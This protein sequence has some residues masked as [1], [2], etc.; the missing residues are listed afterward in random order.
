MLAAP[1][2][3]ELA[4]SAARRNLREAERTASDGHSSYTN[5]SSLTST[6]LSSQYMANTPI[7]FAFSQQLSD[8][9]PVLSAA[10]PLTS[11][12]ENSEPFEDLQHVPV[13]EMDELATE[14]QPEADE[15]LLEHQFSKGSLQMSGNSNPEHHN[16]YHPSRLRCLR[17][18]H[19][20]VNDLSLSAFK[21]SIFRQCQEMH[22]TCSYETDLRA[23]YRTGLLSSN[24]DGNSSDASDHASD[25]EARPHK[26]A[27]RDRSARTLME[28]E[29]IIILAAY[30]HFKLLICTRSPFPTAQEGDILAVD[31]WAA[32]CNEL[33]VPR[34]NVPLNLKIKSRE[35]QVRSTLKTI[36]RKYVVKQYH[37]DN[38]KSLSSIAIEANRVLVESLKVKC[39]FAHIDKDNLTTLCKNPIF[40]DILEDAWFADAGSDGMRY[41]AYFGSLIPL[42][43]VALLLTVV[44]NA[45]DEW[46][47]GQWR[48]VELRSPVYGPRYLK[49]L[50]SLH[51]W[52]EYSVQRSQAH[53]C[54]QRELLQTVRLWA[55]LKN[56][57]TPAAQDDD[58]SD[59]DFA[60]SERPE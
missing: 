26:K 56:K 28:D 23:P 31:A 17:G 30:T 32:A 15:H 11:R 21:L 2:G 20:L 18:K 59:N 41:P 43:T 48:L 50:H 27:R 35:Q 8:S 40:A 49:H 57:L 4:R 52:A 39:A 33:G 14:I 29:Q 10:S 13:S 6:P 54:M 36:A 37:F 9:Q 7:P 51:Q 25:S 45:I 38:N 60:A 55:S 3:S 42:V 19:N 58:L 24:N 5:P 1:L 34:D 53:I 22:M 47:S 12:L 16:G 46:T 44:E